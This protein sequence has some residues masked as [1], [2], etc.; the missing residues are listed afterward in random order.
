M[1][2]LEISAFYHDSTTCLVNDVKSVAAIEE[3][4]IA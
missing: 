3:E 1:Y 4:K 2:I